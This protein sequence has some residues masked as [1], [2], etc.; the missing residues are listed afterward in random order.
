M[1]NGVPFE[2]L[3]ERN[4]QPPSADE[5][6]KQNEK[7]DKLKRETP[8]QR[9]ERL[10]KQAEENASE[11]SAARFVFDVENISTMHY[12]FMTLFHPT[13]MQS[14]YF[15]DRESENVWRYYSI[16]RTGKNASGQSR[17]KSLPRS[18]GR[19]RSIATS[20]EFPPTR[21]LRRRDEGKSHYS[22]FALDPRRRLSLWWGGAALALLIF[23]RITRE[24]IEGDVGAMD[25][26]ILLAVAKTRTHGLGS[27]LWT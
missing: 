8:E 17:E 19:L 6:R 23:V 15:L 12:L 14:I 10:H 21:S 4:G 13:E 2:Q 5:E 1:V 26:A 22:T 18:I 9:A 7:L 11:A 20:L 24:L 3:V 27:W 16:V 25:S